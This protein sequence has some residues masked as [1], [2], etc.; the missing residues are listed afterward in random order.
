[1][2]V[3][4]CVKLGDT[5]KLLMELNPFWKAS[6]I[7]LQ[8]DKK[9]KGK[10]GNYSNNRK[11]VLANAMSEEKLISHFEF[12]AYENMRT[13][14]FFDVYLPEVVGVSGA[15]LFIDKAKDTDALFRS[16][17][18]KIF[19]RHHD[20]ICQA[21]DVE[22]AID[23]TGIT[24]KISSLAVDKTNLFQRAVIEENII[25]EYTP[26][27]E[28]QLIIATLLDR[29]FALA[30]AYTSNATPI[31][32]VLNQLTG[33][34]LIYLLSKSYKMLYNM[35]CRLSWDDV[36]FL[37]QDADW[38]NLISYIN[39]Y[40]YI[41]QESALKKQDF[42]IDRC[43]N[44][45]SHSMFLLSLLRLA[46]SEALNATKS[47]LYEYGLFSEAQNMEAMLDLLTEAYAGKHRILLDIICAIDLTANRLE[48]KLTKDKKYSYLLE[49]S[50]KQKAKNF[51]VLL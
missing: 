37:S 44:K 4:A 38:R 50:R 28:D 43:I 36:F 9:H 21:M 51:D 22:R 23:F 47:K 12:V 8:L 48:E 1:M 14:T 26:V 24:N 25:E 2:S 42:Q 41:V 39:S 45:L 15:D 7:L 30:N 33:K 18:V 46:K 35:I 32:L 31:S 16:E 27:M 17:T 40:I 10:A 19:E 49:I 34:W 11:K 29:S 20:I 5:T 3:P 6:R 13:K